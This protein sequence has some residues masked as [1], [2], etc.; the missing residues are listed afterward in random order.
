MVVNMLNDKTKLR[1]FR[2][3]KNNVY[4]LKLHFNIFY[5]Y[6]TILYPARERI[7]SPI[8]TGSPTQHPAIGEPVQY[9][10][11]TGDVQIGAFSRWTAY[12]IFALLAN[13]G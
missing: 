11:V 7:T 6:R 3:V 8:K 5:Q 1:P 4:K 12:I 13:F 2:L 9:S 10:S